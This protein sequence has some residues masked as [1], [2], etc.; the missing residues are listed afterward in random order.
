[1]VSILT[2]QSRG[3]RIEPRLE[4]IRIFQYQSFLNS[5]HFPIQIVIQSKKLD[6]NQYLKKV[7]KIKESQKNELIRL[8]TED[9]I[10]FVG[11]LINL[12]NIMKKSFYVVIGFDPI[13]VKSGSIIDKLFKKEKPAQLKV[14][15]QDF[16]HYKEQLTERANVVATGLGGMGLHCVQMTTEEIIELFYKIYNPEI[17]DKE[18]FTDINSITPSMVSQ[19]GSAVEA[20][21][22]EESSDEGVID[23]SDLVSERNK[24]EAQAKE[25]ENE[26]AAVTQINSTPGKVPAAPAATTETNSQAPIQNQSNATPATP[27]V[28]QPAPDQPPP[29]NQN[30][31][32]ANNQ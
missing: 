20:K 15:D 18:R 1:M 24:A 13:A 30:P 4:H 3:W 19:K 22:T 10:D 31:P 17:A 12:A 8:Q 32:T 21:E 27:L 16:K 9:Y 26:K 29:S 6:L 25:R 23:N 7:E 5:L 11:Q 2:N 28:N 14:S